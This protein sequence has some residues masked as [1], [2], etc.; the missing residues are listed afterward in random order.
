MDVRE[1]FYN[2]L[3]LGCAHAMKNGVQVVCVLWRFWE[4]RVDP[5]Y[6]RFARHLL[7]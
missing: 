7:L 3:R 6:F 1:S 2:T 4:M 5:H